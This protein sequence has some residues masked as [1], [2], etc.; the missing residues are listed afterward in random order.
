MLYGGSLLWQ[1]GRF[2]MCSAALCTSIAEELFIIS[3]LSRSAERSKRI[4]TGGV[5]AKNG[6][7]SAASYGSAALRTFQTIA[8][9]TK[10][11]RFCISAS[12]MAS[13]WSGRRGSN[14]L[15]PP[16]QGGALPDELRP[17]IRCIYPCTLP[18]DSCE[19]RGPRESL[20]SKIL[21][22]RGGISEF[23]TAVLLVRLPDKR[24][25]FRRATRIGL[26]PTT[27]SVTGWCSNQ[28]SYRATW[29]KLTGSNR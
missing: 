18:S 6:R 15:P 26:E 24:L 9:K 10:S 11:H 25:T 27:P 29:W 22:G 7:C 8:H 13:Y 16:W 23:V 19:F 1:A 2:R 12:T 20:R 4:F 17:H 21:W 28:L 3:R 5:V 14:S